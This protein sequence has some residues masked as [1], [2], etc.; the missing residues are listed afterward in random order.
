[1]FLKSPLR[2]FSNCFCTDLH[3]DT[4]KVLFSITIYIEG[5]PFRVSSISN[6]YFNLRSTNK[7]IYTDHAEITELERDV[8]WTES[9]LQVTAG[10]H[11]VLG[12][13]RCALPYLH[14]QSSSARSHSSGIMGLVTASLRSP[15]PR[16]IEVISNCPFHQE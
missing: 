14:F 6:T 11:H 5:P 8:H 16:N 13:K 1:M 7:V 12:G 10:M 9:C 15:F 4:L 2:R 3:D